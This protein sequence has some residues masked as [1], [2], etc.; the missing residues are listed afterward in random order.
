MIMKPLESLKDYTTIVSMTD[1]GHGGSVDGGRSRRRSLPFGCGIPDGGSSEADDGFRR[2]LRHV[3]RSDVRTEVRSGHAGAVDPALHRERGCVRFLRMHLQ[4]RVHE[5]DQ[6][7]VADDSAADDVESRAW[8]S[9]NCSVPAVPGRSRRAAEA[10][11]QRSGWNHAQRRPAD[12]GSGCPGPEQ[13]QH[14]SGKRSR[15]RAA[16]SGDREIQRQQSRP[17]RCRRRRSACR[18]PGTSIRRSC[19]T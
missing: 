10:E 1:C 17:E 15:D 12:E 19:W 7:V 11:P 18:I 16:D 14:L 4:L 13:A 5:Y 6:L 9:S 8:R 3:D 2:L